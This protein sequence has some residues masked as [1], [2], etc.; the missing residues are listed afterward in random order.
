GLLDTR[1]G[2][3]AIYTLSNLPIV[4]W[5]LY[6]F[7]REVPKEILEASRMDGAKPSQQ[8]LLLLLPLSLPGV[9]STALLSIIICWNEA[10]WSI[11]LT[12]ANARPLTQLIA[13]FSS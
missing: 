4:V 1:I 7:F 11:N 9:F 5:M 8:L 12:A 2:I 10:F 6:S 13:S 3:V